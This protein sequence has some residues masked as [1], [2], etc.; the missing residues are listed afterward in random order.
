MRGADTA[1]YVAVL[2]RWYTHYHKQ[3]AA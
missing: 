2:V 1:G 3:I